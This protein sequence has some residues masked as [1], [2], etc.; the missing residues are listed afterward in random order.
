V[1]WNDVVKWCNARSEREGLTPVYSVNGTIYRTGEVG[2]TETGGATV[3]ETADGFVVNSAA[4]GYRLPREKEWEWAAR[5]GVFSQ[6]YTYSGSNTYSEV[7][8]TKENSPNGD[9]AVGTKLSNELGIHDMSGNVWEWCEDEVNYNQRRI[10]GG[11][12]ADIFPWG[13]A[14]AYRGNMF[15]HQSFGNYYCGFRLA[16]N[17]GN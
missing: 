8:W 12:W 7:A 6:S 11:G 4:N 14:V 3:N 16:R 9:K 15:T 2:V 10:R 13:A 5:G 1:S 17:L